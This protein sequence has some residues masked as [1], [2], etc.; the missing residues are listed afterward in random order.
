[1][2]EEKGKPNPLTAEWLASALPPC[3][4]VS[5]LKCSGWRVIV[6]TET[7]STFQTRTFSSL[8]RSS[9]VASSPAALA[10]TVCTSGQSVRERPKVHLSSLHRP[11]K[12]AKGYPTSNWKLS[13]DGPR[14]SIGRACRSLPIRCLTFSLDVVQ[15]TSLLSLW[16]L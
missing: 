15:H 7:W 9:P 4:P 11:R 13:V 3:L 12:A 6:D 16:P 10:S 8:Q 1:M 2:K 14:I 5:S